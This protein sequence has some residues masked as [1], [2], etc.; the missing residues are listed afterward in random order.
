[1]ER[2]KQT[3]AS[4]WLTMIAATFLFDV[5]AIRISLLRWN[6]LGMN[7]LHSAWGAVLF[8]YLVVL[9]FCVWLFVHIARHG[10]LYPN[11]LSKVD[12]FKI[13]DVDICQDHADFHERLIF[14]EQSQLDHIGNACLLEVCKI[15]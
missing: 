3:T 2:E 4:F 14:G 1:M 8:L 5:A 15:L 6:E 10:E 7:L 11:A 13:C 9:L 12:R